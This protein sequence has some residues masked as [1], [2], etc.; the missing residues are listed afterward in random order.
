MMHILEWKS[1]YFGK[2]YNAV[3]VLTKE[4]IRENDALLSFC[5]R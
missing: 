1:I 5:L 2:K 3:D 4:E